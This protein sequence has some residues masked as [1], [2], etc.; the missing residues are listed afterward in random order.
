MHRRQPVPR[1]W[2]M[3]DQRQG[4]KLLPAV[5]SLPEGAG[6]VFRHYSLGEEA[7]RALFE[8]VRGAA[9][10]RGLVLMLAGAPELAPTWGA[11]GRHGR[12][13]DWVSGLLRS[14]SVHD[15][16]EMARANAPGADLHFVSPMFESRSHPRQLPLAPDECQTLVASARMPVIALGGMDSRRAETL[17]GTGIY[18]WA[19]IDAWTH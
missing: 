1:L 4:E 6:I 5:E 17:S 7:R 13:G 18:G 2:M 19:A 14:V 16:A 12:D 9:R 11:D 10:Q 3:T 8:Q 15:A